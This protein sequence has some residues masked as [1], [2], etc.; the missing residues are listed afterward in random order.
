MYWN[1]KI[2]VRGEAL[3]MEYLNSLGYTL[4]EKNW[5]TGRSEIDIIVQR[6]NELHFIEVKASTSDRFGHPE[7]RISAAKLKALAK[8][9]EKFIELNPAFKEVIFDVLAITM[10]KNQTPLF[11]LIEDIRINP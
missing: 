8:A 6:N 4:I 2:G 1:Q 9:S 10:L 11:F 5:R 3:A 7:E